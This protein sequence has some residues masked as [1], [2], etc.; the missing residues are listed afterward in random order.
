M[1][2]V[3]WAVKNEMACK[4]EDVLAR[5]MRL[6]FLDVPC[7][8]QVAPKVAELMRVLMGKDEKWKQNELESFTLLAKGYLP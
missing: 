8:L 1:A 6:L 2:H 7:T 3:Y 5:R 4:L